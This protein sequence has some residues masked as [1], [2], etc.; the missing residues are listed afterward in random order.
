MIIKHSDWLHQRI[1]E[2]R[3][4]LCVGLDSDITRLPASVLSQEDPVFTFNKEIIDH[5][6]EYCVAYKI[7]TAF[8]ESLGVKGWLSLQ[9]T[10]NYIPSTHLIIADAKR[11]DIGNTS[12][13]YA[14]AF[15]DTLDCDAI[16]VA[17]YMGKD[18]VEPFL[19]Y[20][21]KWTIIL[22]LTSNA[23]S[24]DFQMIQ[25]NEGNVP[26][27]ET[28]LN[29]SKQWGSTDQL[30]YV[31]G[32][33]KPEFFEQ[34]RTIIPDHFLLV[35]GVGAQGGDL[36]AVYKYGNNSKVGLLINSSRGIIFA[37]NNYDFAKAAGLKAKA[38]QTKM[39]ELLES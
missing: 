30:M 29:T 15:F 10:I 13:Q 9:K 7:N 23:G 8:Y 35:P 26:L 4:F 27:F 18:S 19:S 21:D 36:E 34:I 14:K 2:T 39:Q 22:G 20:Q 5:T 33:T 38:I 28:V 32:A 16:T 3:S 1:L 25:S 17:P 6:S 37:S 24:Q 12:L 31:V 11:G